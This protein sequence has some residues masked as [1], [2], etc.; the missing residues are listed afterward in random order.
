MILLL[1]TYH[2]IHCIWPSSPPSGC[3]GAEKKEVVRETSQVHWPCCWGPEVR[4]WTHV[5]ANILVQELIWVH[6]MYE[7]LR[8]M[9]QNKKGS[10]TECQKILQ[11]LDKILD[12]G[13][14]MYKTCGCYLF[15]YDTMSLD[16]VHSKWYNIIFLCTYCSKKKFK[17]K[18]NWDRNSL[19]AVS[20]MLWTSWVTWSRTLQRSRKGLKTRQTAS[21]QLCALEWNMMRYNYFRDFILVRVQTVYLHWIV[22][23]VSFWSI[24]FAI[25]W[26]I[27]VFP[28]GWAV[29]RAGEAGEES[30]WE[31]LWVGQSGGET[32]LSQI[33]THCITLPPW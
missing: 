8:E 29:G 30:G 15:T 23:F 18:F 13:S 12:T 9:K 19:L 20:E 4:S 26:N 16:P 21:T 32:L 5:R 25:S 6:D 17:E 22:F 28:S 11:I 10:H 3:A 1:S 33:V 14:K 27:Y 2:L 24:I 31:S 7:Y